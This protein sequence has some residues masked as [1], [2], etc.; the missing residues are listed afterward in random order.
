M[1]QDEEKDDDDL[2]PTEEGIYLDL[3]EEDPDWNKE[4]LE[5]RER[6]ERMTLIVGIVAYSIFGAFLIPALFVLVPTTIG[7]FFDFVVFM[8]DRYFGS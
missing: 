7:F 2:Y 5:K 8:W 4:H 1:N 3:Y 6:E